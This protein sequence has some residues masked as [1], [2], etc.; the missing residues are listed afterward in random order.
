MKINTKS[1]STPAARW[2]TVMIVTT[3]DIKNKPAMTF[4]VVR[5]K[6]HFPSHLSAIAKVSTTDFVTEAQVY[7]PLQAPTNVTTANC[8]NTPL[9]PTWQT[10]N[11]SSIATSHLQSS[12]QLQRFQTCSGLVASLSSLL[13]TLKR[14]LC[15]RF[16]LRASHTC[17]SPAITSS[18]YQGITRTTIMLTTV[19]RVLMS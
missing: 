11:R 5:I 19:S 6:N 7:Q 17:L 2:T 1:L 16:Y 9:Q 15:S 8:L 12:R 13:M 3:M 18:T 14:N 4:T 10:F